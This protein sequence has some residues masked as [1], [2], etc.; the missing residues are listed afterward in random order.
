MA[1]KKKEQQKMS[2]GAFLT[3]EKMGS[4]AD[5]MEDMP[6]YSRTGYGSERRTYN[7]NTGTYGGASMGGYSVREELPL[8]DKPPYT[9]HLG[10]LSF[11]AT[12]G[13]VTDFFADCEC[14]NVRIIEDKLEM[15]P[16]GFGYAEFG[17]LD[18][19]K[20]ALT[21]NG[22]QFQGRNIRISVADPPKDRDRPDARVI[23]DWSRKGPLPDLP[24]RG[25]AGGGRR[26]SERDF[27]SDF[28]DRKERFPEGDGKVRDFGN[29]ERKGPLSPMPQPDRG[30]REGGRPRD[31]G[32]RPEGFMER[33]A[34]PA[35]WGEGRPQG[36]QDGSRP[37]RREF[38]ERPAV[39]RAPTAA[40]QDSQWRT[41][42]RPDAPA[43]KSP[44]PSRDG[45]EAPSSPAATPATLAAPG[46]RPKLNLAKRTVSEAQDLPSPASASGDAKSSP[47][48]AARPIDTAAKEREIEE[49]RLAVLREKKEA[50][51]KAK[52]EQK[53][54]AKAKAEAEKQESAE[55]AEKVEQK[56]EG[57]EAATVEK[58]DQN[59]TVT[60]DKAVK[61]N[62]IVRDAKPARLAD[63]GTWRR[64]SGGP[65]TPRDDIPR[66]PRG[67]GGARG[68]GDGRGPR[69][70]DDRPAR[71]N[72]NGGASPA[73]PAQPPADSETAA[74]EGDGW[75][76]VSKP[77]KGGRGGNQAARAIAS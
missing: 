34:S 77:K 70:Y 64:A 73:S 41:K 32:P 8:P 55:A 49:K 28:G 72:T 60:D 7:S 46:G 26:E 23:T 52:Q 33:K 54:A 21:L 48:G 43:A 65:P 29:W 31:D 44:V 13:D 6:V 35:A 63:T 50:D 62:T 2:L 57:D 12:V 53:E 76:T 11:D 14:T 47:F 58:E 56:A 71:Q 20:Q 19:L 67:R 10:N 61:P 4:W 15:K 36:S 16:K 68:R 1:P 40:E 45:S 30:L 9:V 74:L 18:G 38:Q 66:G 37:P 25:G 69:N 3:D 42:M 22:S 24:N 17:T 59:G 27:G 5:E 51:E 39:D 75:S